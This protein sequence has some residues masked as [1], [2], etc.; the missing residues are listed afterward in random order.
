MI[1]KYGYLKI[2]E[3]GQVMLPTDLWKELKLKTVEERTFM[4]SSNGKNIVLSKPVCL[5]C[6][7]RPVAIEMDGIGFCSE[8]LENLGDKLTW[9]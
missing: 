6:G 2:D 1:K 8:C 9:N 5:C 7:E 4:V 3:K